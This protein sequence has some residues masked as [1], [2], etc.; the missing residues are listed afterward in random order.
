MKV[1]I[2]L[3]P[4][5]GT[6]AD[7]DLGDAFW[8][9]ESPPNRA[10]AERAWA[11]GKTDLNSAVY[12]PSAGSCADE[13]VIQRFE[14]AD[15]HHPTWNEMAFAGVSLSPSLKEHFTRLGLQVARRAA[16][17]SVLRPPPGAE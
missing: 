7:A 17:F 13:D 9:V 14:D 11:L 8:V 2:A 6:R 1:I 12:K 15:L 10:L 5:Y 3:D 16:S 4:A